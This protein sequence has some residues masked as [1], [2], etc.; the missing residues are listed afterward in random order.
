MNGE[1]LMD[2]AYIYGCR[3]GGSQWLYILLDK[4][5]GKD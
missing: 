4:R 1:R 2:G 3:R 5:Q